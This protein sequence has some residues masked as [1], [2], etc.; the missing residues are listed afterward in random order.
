M[1]LKWVLLMGLWTVKIFSLISS[2]QSIMWGKSRSPREYKTLSWVS[3]VDR[4]ICLRVTVSHHEAVPSDAK[5]WPSDGF[6]LSVPNNHDRF[7]FLHTFWPPAFA[8]NVGVTINVSCSYTL[9]SAILKVYYVNSQ[10]LK[11]RVMWPPYNQ[12]IDNTCCDLI[13]SIPSVG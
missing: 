2:H 4:K 6:F 8:F 10:R 13:L 5:Q 11:D 1:T 3:G 9:M 12:C 7:F